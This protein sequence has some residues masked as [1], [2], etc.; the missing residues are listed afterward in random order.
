VC[1]KPELILILLAGKLVSSVGKAV[2][3][4]INP[5]EKARLF[6]VLRPPLFNLV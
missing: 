1:L 6:K 5:V 2:A 4:I 3:E